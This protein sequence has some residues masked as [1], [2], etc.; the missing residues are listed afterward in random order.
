MVD[1][2]G[3]AP[4]LADIIGDLRRGIGWPPA[5]LR[6]ITVRG[7]KR[8]PLRSMSTGHRSTAI[9]AVG[10]VA[11]RRGGAGRGAREATRDRL[12]GATLVFKP[13]PAARRF[14]AA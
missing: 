2:Q 4:P 7:R 10:A 8:L 12:H 11:R 14:V 5:I 3:A 9:G 6:L 13:H 1:G